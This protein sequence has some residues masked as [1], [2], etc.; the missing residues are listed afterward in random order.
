[1]TIEF[2]P[3]LASPSP[4]LLALSHQ[5]PKDVSPVWGEML[6]MPTFCNWP[7]QKSRAK[8]VYQKVIYGLS[9]LVTKKATR[10]MVKTP[11]C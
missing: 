11:P 6:R 10:G 5:A 1:M 3:S 7:N 9:I 2:K 4:A 8:T